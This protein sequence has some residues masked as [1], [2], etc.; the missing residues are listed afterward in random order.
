[1]HAKNATEPDRVF[2]SEQQRYD[3]KPFGMELPD[4]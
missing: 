3:Y 1:M 2:K 4:L